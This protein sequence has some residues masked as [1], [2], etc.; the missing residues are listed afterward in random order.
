MVAPIVITLGK[1]LGEPAAKKVWEWSKGNEAEQLVKVLK[2]QFPDAYKLLTQPSVL[3]E[4]YVYAETG[5]FK[6]AEMVKALRAITGSPEEA[7]ALAE[8]IRENQ[9]RAM[10]EPRQMH[11][12]LRRLRDEI[13]GDV[14]AGGEQV[15]QRLTEAIEKL[16]RRLPVARQLP[17]Q[18]A[19][20][21]D[22][23]RELAEGER[24]LAGPAAG[25]VALVVN[26]TGMSGA[27]TSVFA[28]ELAYRQMGSFGG[29]VLYA[30]M[31]SADGRK[32]DA[33]DLAGRLLRDLGVGPDAIPEDP[34]RRLALWRSVCAEEPVMIVLDNA[35]SDGAVAALIPS[36]GE[37][38]VIVTSRA[39]LAALAGAGLIELVEMADT[40]G[41]ALLEAIV[42][43]RVREEPDA[44]R[45][46]VGHCCGL[47]LA[48]AVIAGRLRAQ[49][50]ARLEDMARALAASQ[51]ILGG[52]DDRVG[53]IRATL[54]SGLSDV[55][56]EARRVLLLLAA[57]QVSDVEPALVA[58]VAGCDATS[59]G[60][61]LE[62]L[63]E[64]RLI[65]ALQGGGWRIHDLL[66]RAASALASSELGEQEIL[67]ARDR[68]V[69]WLVETARE[70]AEDLEGEE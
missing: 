38:I 36:R 23:D 43:E 32:R 22:R 63:G 33:A 12:E 41:L 18:T 50:G 48:L 31:R 60:R 13:G 35:P 56:S 19:P 54:A 58:A 55:G 39:P 3:V 64:Q 10:R 17:A 44:A 25:H 20:F 66:R 26:C 6:T 68:R 24:K 59:A 27:G 2:S 16:A 30:D 14:A 52:L 46:I 7:A 29:G 49:P 1:M 37:S 70:H 53:T 4:L 21:V 9:W 61:L 42:G 57:L 34:E 11:F 51:D 62:E 15:V 40:D 8:A 47:A 5:V 28:L 45:E 67:S 65:T 69:Q